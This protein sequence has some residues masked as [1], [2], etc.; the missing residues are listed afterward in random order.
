MGSQGRYI[1]LH[2]SLYYYHFNLSHDLLLAC[3]QKNLGHQMHE[4]HLGPMDTQVNSGDIGP[5]LF[6]Q[7]S[8]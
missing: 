4:K 7:I 5:N 2:M 3:F 8:I 1:S 6:L